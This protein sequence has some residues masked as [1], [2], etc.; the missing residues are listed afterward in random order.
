MYERY[1]LNDIAG[2]S[3]CHLFTTTVVMELTSQGIDYISGDLQMLN[4][5]Y[6]QNLKDRVGV[7][8]ASKFL[9][10]LSLFELSIFYF[11]LY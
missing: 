11:Q 4:I 6:E 10:N 1:Q 3:A 9:F 5:T 2:D 8:Y 7:N